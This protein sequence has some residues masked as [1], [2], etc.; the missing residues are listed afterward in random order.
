MPD[1]PAGIRHRRR[2]L[3]PL[4]LALALA[5]PC[6]AAAQAGATS[7]PD[8]RDRWVPAISVFGGFLRLKHHG[9]FTSG[10]VLGP[11]A[12]DDE[13]LS[14][15]KIRPDDAGF[16][17][18]VAPLVGG[19]L[20]L[21]TPRL[22]E[23]GGSPRLFAHGDLVGSFSDERT[24]AGEKTPGDIALPTLPNNVNELS[25]VFF[26]GQG[27]RTKSELQPLVAS[28]GLGVAF[29][30]DLP[31]RRI[32]IKPSFEYVRE[33]VEVKGV[34]QRVV[35]IVDPAPVAEGFDDNFRLLQLTGSQRKTLHGVG[36]GLEVEGDAARLGPFMLSVYLSGQG[37]RFLGSRAV[38]FTDTNEFG[39]TAQ[40]SFQQ[41][42]WAWG[43][44]I[45]LRFRW[46]PE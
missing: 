1:R 29:S 32:R 41:D 25:E 34:V 12:V 42:A 26:L 16:S 28:A 31:T 20:E 9:S 33:E 17:T 13:E 35:Q 5:L 40:W 14:P 37:Y 43:G 15:T 4:L 21:M 38:R 39:E 19:S 7:T 27:S 6:S 10:D 36:A 11:K 8:E 2:R 23:A 30:V 44:R 46:L 18:P 45:G 24:L 3:A 22:F